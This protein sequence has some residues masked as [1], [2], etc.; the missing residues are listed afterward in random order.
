MDAHYKKI[1]EFHS[2]IA[3][4]EAKLD[5]NIDKAF[6]HFLEQTKTNK[7]HRFLPDRELQELINSHRVQQQ[8][9]TLSQRETQ[10]SSTQLAGDET[11]LQD[12]TPTKYGQTNVS[13]THAKKPNGSDMPCEATDQLKSN[14]NVTTE[15][16]IQMLTKDD[17]EGCSPGFSQE[18]QQFV[19]TRIHT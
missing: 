10:K 2:G 13:S 19:F 1:T 14:L 8:T 6:T 3:K 15:E 11:A 12:G 16:I 7:N 9:K 4:E 17:M 5:V 18:T